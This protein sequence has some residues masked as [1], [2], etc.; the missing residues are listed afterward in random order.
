MHQHGVLYSHN[1]VK[2]TA[3]MVYLRVAGQPLNNRKLSSSPTYPAC[4]TT[5]SSPRVGCKPLRIDERRTHFVRRSS[6]TLPTSVTTSGTVA[7][8]MRTCYV[9]VGIRVLRHVTFIVTFLEFVHCRLSPPDAV[10]NPPIIVVDVIDAGSKRVIHETAIGVSRY[11]VI[12]VN[13]F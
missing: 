9:I 3:L 7:R 4:S 2:S 11:D 10:V 8:K 13:R 1:S 6:Q 5:F 12:Q